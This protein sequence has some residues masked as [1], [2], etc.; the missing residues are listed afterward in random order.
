M[1][2]AVRP[3]FE[4]TAAFFSPESDEIEQSLS[5]PEKKE[6]YELS[7]WGFLV[8]IHSYI[9]PTLLLTRGKSSILLW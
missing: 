6:S 2:I 3:C 9:R 1:G 7:F 5:L 8:Q 4:Y